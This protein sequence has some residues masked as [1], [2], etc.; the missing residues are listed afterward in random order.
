ML[1]SARDVMRGAT[2]GYKVMRLESHALLQPHTLLQPQATPHVQH[3]TESA[4]AAVGACRT[5]P[6]PAHT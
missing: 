4:P 5:C 3:Q 2:A 6:T 1:S